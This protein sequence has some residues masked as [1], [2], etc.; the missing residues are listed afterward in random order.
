[1]REKG[2]KKNEPKDGTFRLVMVK[3]LMNSLQLWLHK[4]CTQ[5]NLSAFHLGRRL[6]KLHP[7]LRGFRLLMFTPGRGISFFSVAA[8]NKL[9]M[10]QQIIS[11]QCSCG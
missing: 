3:A 6:M 10:F 1:L 5:L 4:A 7:F 11:H 8:T 9:P 2:K